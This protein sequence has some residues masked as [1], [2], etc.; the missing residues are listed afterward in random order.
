MNSLE[1]VNAIEVTDLRKSYGALEVIKD[2]SFSAK[3]HEVVSLIGA[4]GSGKSTILRCLNL[5]EVP[6]GGQIRIS[7]AELP[8]DPTR[9]DGI[10]D[11]KKL[12]LLRSRLGMVFQ[13]FNLWSHMTILQNVTEAPIRVMGIPRRE[14]EARAMALLDRVGIA[15][16]ASRFPAQL[17]GGQQ[18]RAAIART[19]ATDPDVLLFDEPTSALDPEMVGEVLEVMRDLAAEGRTMIVVTHEMAFARDVSD[20]IIFLEKGRIAEAG[21]PSSIFSAPKTEGCR[22]FLKKILG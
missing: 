5:L 2:V 4:S 8:Y 3:A 18:Q 19:L 22:R 21:P 7:G 17:S 16:K 15:D 12:R 13:N 10:S 14:A 20:H 1:A 11:R 9:R 6:C